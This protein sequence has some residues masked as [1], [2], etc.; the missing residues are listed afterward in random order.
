MYMH[1]S[2][3]ALFAQVLVLIGICFRVQLLN[4]S[5]IIFKQPYRHSFKKKQGLTQFHLKYQRI[6]V[7][8]RQ[9][10]HV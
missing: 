6:R 7:V 5:Q 4:F 2:V 8:L 1:C 10:P 9:T 3:Q